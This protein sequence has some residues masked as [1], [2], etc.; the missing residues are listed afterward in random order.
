MT[1]NDINRKLSSA[2]DTT[3][4]PDYWFTKISD[5]STSGNPDFAIVSAAGFSGWEVKHANPTFK[6]NGIQHLTCR[7]LAKIAKCWYLIF[8]AVT[9]YVYCVEPEHLWDWRN[10]GIFLSSSFDYNYVARY[11]KEMHD[12]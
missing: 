12:Q 9:G 10:K 7:R 2:L 11:M 1:E 8:D 6:S 3:L 4:T 5:R